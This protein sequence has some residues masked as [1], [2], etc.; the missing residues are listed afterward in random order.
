MRLIKWLDLVSWALWLASFIID[1]VCTSRY[2]Y[3]NYPNV[4]LVVTILWLIAAAMLFATQ[5]VK[6][7][8][9]RRERR[10]RK[11][12]EKMDEDIAAH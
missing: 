3:G 4:R 5:L 10:T 7:R 6:Y 8:E 9:H 12:K 2:G 1:L 11:E